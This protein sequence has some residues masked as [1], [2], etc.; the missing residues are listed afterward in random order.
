MMWRVPRDWVGETAFIVAGGPSVN[1]V[2]LRRLSGQKVI[3]INSSYKVVPNADYLVFADHRWWVEHRRSVQD[4]FRGRVVTLTPNRPL[5]EDCC[6]LERQRSGGV[7]ADP[8]R[9]VCMHTTLTT[10]LNL[11]LLLGAARVGLLGVDGADATD[12]RSW[13]HESHPAIWGRNPRRY[14]HHGTALAEQAPA[15]RAASLEVLNLNPQSAHRMFAFA[16][17]DDMIP[18]QQMEM[19]A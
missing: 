15:L 14:E 16:T 3:A 8:S 13:H 7:S 5:Y 18:S 9:L 6:V 17:L 4:T 1:S 12:G 19:F 2:D 10:A 11:A